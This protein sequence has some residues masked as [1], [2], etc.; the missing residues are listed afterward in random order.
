M[1]QCFK[2]NKVNESER[3]NERTNKW[4]ESRNEPPVMMMVVIVVVAAAMPVPALAVVAFHDFELFPK[5]QLRD[6]YTNFTFRFVFIDNAFCVTEAIER[7][8]YTQTHS[9]TFSHLPTS[10]TLSYTINEQRNDKID[11]WWSASGGGRR[12]AVVV[13]AAVVV[14]VGYRRRMTMREFSILN[15]SATETFTYLCWQA[16]YIHEYSSMNR[17]TIEFDLWTKKKLRKN[18]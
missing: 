3:P 16:V 8:R 18:R 13:I 15:Q 12:V 1:K 5:T 14:V 4:T 9:L 17:H 11:Q 6:L 10:L 2:R 7:N